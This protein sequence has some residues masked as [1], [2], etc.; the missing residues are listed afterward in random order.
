[1]ITTIWKK[2]NDQ[3]VSSPCEIVFIDSKNQICQG[4]VN[5]LPTDATTVLAFRPLVPVAKPVVKEKKFVAYWNWKTGKFWPFKS[6]T[7]PNEKLP[8]YFRLEMSYTDPDDIKYFIH[9]QV[10]V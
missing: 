1:M 5:K 10:I 3:Q 6:K 9:S 2:Y 7:I 8:Y 4:S